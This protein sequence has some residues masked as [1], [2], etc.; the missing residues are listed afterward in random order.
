MMKFSAGL[1]K[2]WKELTMTLIGWPVW[3]IW[4]LVGNAWAL[5]LY[6]WIESEP[7]LDPLLE[8]ML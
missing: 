6:G 1:N 4:D 2:A 5:Y 8:T 7:E 3:L